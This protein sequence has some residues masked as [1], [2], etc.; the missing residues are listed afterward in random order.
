M[1]TAPVQPLGRPSRIGTIDPMDTKRRVY[2]D[3]TLREVKPDDPTAAFVF[4]RG[5][6]EV[7]KARRE[8][9]GLTTGDE[10]RRAHLDSRKV[11]ADKATRSLRRATLEAELAKLDAEDKATGT[12]TAPATPTAPVQ[13]EKERLVARASALGLD[14]EGTIAELKDRIA[15]A[16]QA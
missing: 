13:T 2:T 12:A 16:E 1:A 9:L 3:D 8:E 6:F 4:K 11:E 14:T 15:A 7:R 10:A 5:E